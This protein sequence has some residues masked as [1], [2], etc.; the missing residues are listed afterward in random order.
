MDKNKINVI[1]LCGGQGERLRPLTNTTPKPLV[2]VN[3]KSILSY[4]LERL[5]V[6]DIDCIY[7]ATGYL[8]E[9]ID[10]FVAN[11]TNKNLTIKNIYT[12]DKDIIFRIL[13]CLKYFE[14]PAL[15]LY[16]DTLA[17][18]NVERLIQNCI[19]NNKSVISAIPL[20]SQFGLFKI[21]NDII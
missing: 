20:K 12:G 9:K 1:I 17:D 6:Y 3:N 14:G 13:E 10:Y 21:N 11:Q 19:K 16:G 8:H 18:V 7:L 5:S 4:I 15:V 2:K